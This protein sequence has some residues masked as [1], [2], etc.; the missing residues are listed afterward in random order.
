M[1]GLERRL[2]DEKKSHGHNDDGGPGVI[3]ENINGDSRPKRPQLD[4]S[5]LDESAVY[6]PTPPRSGYS[7]FFFSPLVVAKD[8]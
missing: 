3:E 1:D 8:V 5:L 6:S 4:T 7:F 2:K